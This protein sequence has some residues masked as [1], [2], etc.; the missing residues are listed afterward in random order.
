MF[1][2][3]NALLNSLLVCSLVVLSSLSNVHAESITV[4]LD[5]FI[6]PDHATLIVAKQNGLFQ[7][8]GLD[9]EIVEPAD[10]T[11]PPKLAAAQKADL[12]IS[13]QPSLMIDLN[14]DLPLVRVGTLI[15]SPLNSLVVL[16]DGPIKS[17]ADLKGSTIGF[18][19]G[20]FEDA[21]LD[22][23]LEQQGLSL[24][25]VTLVNVNFALA[26]SL[27]SGQVDAV[28]GAFRNFELNQMDID[29]RPGRAFFPEEHGVPMYE[30]LIL[31]AHPD[32]ASQPKIQKFLN[33]LDETTLNVRRD[34]EAAWKDFISYRPDD[35]D[36]ELNKRAWRDTLPKLASRIRQ[37]DATQWQNFAEFMKRRG[38]IESV[39]ETTSYLVNIE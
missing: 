26:S 21:L 16:E 37:T 1:N 9:V 17:I 27:Y 25:D 14:N 8:V 35:L 5:W 18:S 11:L 30:E 36:N 3:I 13:Y 15:D 32:S 39:P 31:V 6:N 38:L 12:A 7:E 2:Q 22:T 19:V 20:G 24:N 10:P 4:L 33:V 28:I 29:E 34:P 23:M